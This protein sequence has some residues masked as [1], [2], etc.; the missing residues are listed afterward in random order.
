M[1]ENTTVTEEVTPTETVEEVTPQEPQADEETEVEETEETNLADEDEETPFIEGLTYKNAD[2]LVKGVKE[3]DATISRLNQEMQKLAQQQQEQEFV[4]QSQQVSG[5]IQTLEAQF[6]QAI[7]DLEIQYNTTLQQ[8]NA[9]LNDGYIDANTYASI[10]QQENAKLLNGKSHLGS[11]FQDEATKIRTQETELTRQRIETGFKQFED[12]N[13]DKLQQPH[14]KGLYES[15]KAKG[16]DPQD[17][18]VAMELA[19]NF[20]SAY[21]KNEQSKQKIKA[22]VD[23]D[24]GQL[25]TTAGKVVKKGVAPKSIDDLAKMSDADYKKYSKKF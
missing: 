17:L 25:T 10:V 20:L 8:A 14:Y 11:I 4:Q 24:K 18:S 9:M 1:E 19:E 23:A 16:Y 15:Y 6:G 13:T 3:K 12:S 22:D 5:K 2:E 21:L 7:N